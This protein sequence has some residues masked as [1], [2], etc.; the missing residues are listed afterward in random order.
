MLG[1]S[2]G[3]FYDGKR[4]HQLQLSYTTAAPGAGAHG[5]DAA[6]NVKSKWM[7][8]DVATVSLRF[9]VDLNDSNNSRRPSAEQD[10]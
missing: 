5:K 4:W 8:E 1:A 9:G 10:T 7:P 3:P 2:T 6:R